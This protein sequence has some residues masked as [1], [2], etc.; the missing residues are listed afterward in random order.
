MTSAPTASLD[1][2]STPPPRHAWDVAWTARDVVVG[3]VPAVVWILVTRLFPDALSAGAAFASWLAL[4]SWFALFPLVMRR[5]RADAARHRGRLL[6]S[7]GWGL[8]AG[9]GL[10][11]L[12]AIVT[13][14]S[15]LVGARIESIS[16]P[17]PGSG[18]GSATLFITFALFASTVGP[19]AE[20]LFFRGFLLHALRRRFRFPIAVIG[21]AA[22][23]ATTHPYGLA[24]SITILS[25]GT[26][27]GLLARIRGTLVVAI[28]AHGVVNATW[29][30]TALIELHRE[31]A[32]LGVAGT[33]VSDGHD[34]YIQLT[35]VEP[36][37]PAARAGLQVGDQLYAVD[38]WSMPT[39]FAE[40]A[41]Y[42]RTYDT[43]QVVEVIFR[44]GARHLRTTVTFGTKPR[45]P[46]APEDAGRN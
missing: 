17:S 21:Q 8:L 40:F 7:I 46:S 16:P 10:M 11:V 13:A 6:P 45:P 1:G 5:R 27:L 20:E 38:G 24:S 14:I 30:G 32:W 22:L 39:T 25:V 19:W 18:A 41:S 44:R 3:L 28:V 15:T 29:A 33:P 35:M 2:P 9:V 12:I 37:S 43:G 31:V 23:F 4:F 36:F 26:A 34:S 42:V